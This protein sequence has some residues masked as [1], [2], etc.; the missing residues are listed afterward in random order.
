M[1]SSFYLTSEVKVEVR[2]F[3]YIFVFAISRFLIKFRDPKQ[4]PNE[5][6]QTLSVSLCDILLYH[7]QAETTFCVV[8]TLDISR[9]EY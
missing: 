7:L 3:K 8:T 2:I 1:L 6:P 9:L 5:M 4:D